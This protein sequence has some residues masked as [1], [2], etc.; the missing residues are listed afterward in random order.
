MA[1]YVGYGGAVKVGTTT[2]AEIG[3]W[4]LDV[5]LNTEGAES[6]GDQW[7]E[8]IGT[9][10][11]WS[12]SCSGRW[13]MTD[14]QGQKAM[15]DALLGGTTVT[16][17]LYVDGTKNYSGTALITKIS[18]KA[19]VEGVVEVSFDFQGTGALTYSAT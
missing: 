1:V 13:D 14:T 15:Q 2:V 3:E 11:E 17:K 10:K 4:S 7:K 12:G 5:T 18:P 8:F 6:F 16:L 9:L 19:S